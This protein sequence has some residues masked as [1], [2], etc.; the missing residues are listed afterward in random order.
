MEQEM[1]NCYC[2][3]GKIQQHYGY[4]FDDVYAENIYTTNIG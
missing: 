4:S 3:L 1:K 2:D